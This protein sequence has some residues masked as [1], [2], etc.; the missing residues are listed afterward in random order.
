MKKGYSLIHVHSNFSYGDSIIRLDDYIKKAKEIEC[1]AASITEH[2]NLASALTIQKKCLKE[3][4]KP[5]LG[6]EMYIS[7]IGDT[8][9][10]IQ[11]FIAD[12]KIEKESNP[13]ESIES[14]FY[15][16]HL[17][18]YAISKKGWYNLVKIN[19]DAQY[20]FYRKPLGIYKTIYDNSEDIA[21]TTACI[22]S[23]INQMFKMYGYGKEVVKF[24]GELKDVFSDRVFLEVQLNHLEQ[25]GQYNF[26]LCNLARDLNMDLIYG[27]DAHH[28]NTDDKLARYVYKSINQKKTIKDYK[29][30]L[31]PDLSIPTFD[32]IENRWQRFDGGKF[33]P[34]EMFEASVANTIKFAELFDSQV[35][36]FDGYKVSSIDGDKI[37]TMIN[38][39]RKEL[40]NIGE[41]E[42]PVY[43][44]RIT[45]EIETFTTLGVWGYIYILWDAISNTPNVFT[46]FG[47]GS[48]TGSLFCY[49]L[50]LT[51]I[52]PIRY[53]LSFERFLNAEQ[54]QEF[55]L[56]FP[57]V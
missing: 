39:A 14:Y 49:L 57:D 19:N 46:G 20:R 55:K 50:G 4:I 35:I 18:L 31:E 17:C 48:V 33:M 34:H 1:Q 21:I 5:L 2:G 11:K 56:E 12:K 22:Q 43:N 45:N 42:N 52:D 54:G 40:S 47:R 15:R 29:E 25:Q 24:V 41:A 30:E 38:A 27:I 13:E 3:G 37:S 8:V 28:I 6:I 9:E 53:N 26:A 10:D 7:E 16:S 51:K 44:D 32:E 36:F 23:R